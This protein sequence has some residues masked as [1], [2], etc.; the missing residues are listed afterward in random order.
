[1]DHGFQKE[2][3]YWDGLLEEGKIEEYDVMAGPLLGLTTVQN[4][5]LYSYALY[6]NKAI[7]VKSWLATVQ[8]WL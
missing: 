7:L 8:L 2:S 3:E 6:H 4:M 1:V 5:V